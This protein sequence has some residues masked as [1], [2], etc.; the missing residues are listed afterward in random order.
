MI[1]I[2]NSIHYQFLLRG[3]PVAMPYLHT[4]KN[5]CHDLLL[6]NCDRFC[7]SLYYLY[8]YKNYHNNLKLKSVVSGYNGGTKSIESNYNVTPNNNI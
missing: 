7:F 3:W 4:K 5:S 2:N 1:L 8:I 6:N